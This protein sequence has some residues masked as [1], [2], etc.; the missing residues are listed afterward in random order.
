M[1]EPLRGMQGGASRPDEGHGNEL[2]DREVEASLKGDWR[3]AHHVRENMRMIGQAIRKGWNIPDS[4]L[5]ELPAEVL[6]IWHNQHI[7]L[8][9][10]MKALET[11]I[12]MYGQNLK[13]N[14]TK[15]PQAQGVS[16]TVNQYASDGGVIENQAAVDAAATWIAAM[17]HDE[18][19]PGGLGVVR[20]AGAVQSPAAL[21]P[22]EQ[23]AG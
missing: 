12:R 21:G 11:Y 3:D 9:V 6:E 16:V 8:L 22:P 10:R 23:D 1:P 2:P 5:D 17:A 20:D 7:P 13:A 4:A 18:V 15:E 14:E 19:H